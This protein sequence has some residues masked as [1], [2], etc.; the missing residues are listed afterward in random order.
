MWIFKR[1]VW[2]HL[3]VNAAGMPFSQELKIEAHMKGF[4]C[5]EIPISYR[6]RVG[7]VK[8]STY[9]DGIGNAMHLA[10]K[11]ISVRKR[12]TQRRHTEAARATG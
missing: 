10:K 2:P 6:A 12:S 11:R 3:N 7:A 9:K 8:L 4:N 1:T 5:A